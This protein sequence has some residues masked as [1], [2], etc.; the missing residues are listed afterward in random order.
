VDVD[1]L[2][3]LI[4]GVGEVT[5][6]ESE[7]IVLPFHSYHGCGRSGPRR[8]HRSVA[9]AYGEHRDEHDLHRGRA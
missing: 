5:E 8:Q 4:I 3:E 2:I 6:R 7:A 9:E 1:N